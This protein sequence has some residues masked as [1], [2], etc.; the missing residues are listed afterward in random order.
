MEPLAGGRTKLTH[1]ENFSG[2]LTLVLG[3]SLKPTEVG[4]TQM[5]EA[6]KTRAEGKA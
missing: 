1:G 5:N 4:F 6:L 2:Q 3:G